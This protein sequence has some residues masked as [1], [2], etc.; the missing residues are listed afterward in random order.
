L[1]ITHDIIID[2]AIIDD[3]T[4]LFIISLHWYWLLH[5]C[6]HYCWYWYYYY[7]IIITLLLIDIIIDYFH[8][9]IDYWLLF[10]T[11]FHID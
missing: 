9:I 1:M 3:I 6:W 7:F 4:P 10:S 11:L 8:L 5:Y 2:Y